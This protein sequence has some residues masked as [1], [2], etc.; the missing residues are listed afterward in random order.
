MASGLK[1]DMLVSNPKKGL[2]DRLVRGWETTGRW[3]EDVR[4][5]WNKIQSEGESE[6]VTSP[7][8]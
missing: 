4:E 5:H 3:G 1:E 7:A 6:N 8:L 2:G